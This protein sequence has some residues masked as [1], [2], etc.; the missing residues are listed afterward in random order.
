MYYKGL[1]TGYS[2][3][4][5]IHKFFGTALKK[6]SDEHGKGINLQ[7]HNRK[8]K[9]KGIL[10]FDVTTATADVC[11]KEAIDSSLFRAFSRKIMDTL[12]ALI[13]R[14][15]VLNLV[16]EGQCRIYR[17]LYGISNL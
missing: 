5:S 15:I 14:T 12:K 1:S 13:L 3:K 7:F 8:F 2:R 17:I 4:K 10:D 9:R 6:K 11:M 16:R